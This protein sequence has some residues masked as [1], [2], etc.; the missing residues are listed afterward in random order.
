MNSATKNI[1]LVGPAHPLRGGIATFNEQLARSLQAQGH[2]VEILSFSLQYPDFIFPG[3]SQFTDEPPPTDLK[4][5]SKM[6]AINPL[7]WL[8]IGNEYRKKKY[9][10]IIFRFWLPLMSPCLGTIARLIRL[11]Q[12][13]STKILAITD[14]VIPH[15]KRIGDKIFTKYFLAACDGFIAMAKAVMEDINL[16]EPKKPKVYTPHPIYDNYGEEISREQALKNLNLS[17]ENQYILF[18][19]LIRA[20]KGLDLLLEAFADKRLRHEKVK[21]IIAGEPYESMDKYAQIIEK[22]NLKTEIIS[23]LHFIPTDQVANYFCAADLIA[24]PYKTAT[25]SGVSQI[26]YHFNKPMLVTDVGGLAETVPH[27]KVGYVT[28]QNPTEIANYLVDFFE[29]K[30]AEAF[31]TAIKIEKKRFEWTTLIE[32]LVE[33]SH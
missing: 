10:L 23:H 18:F 22:Y 21:L 12:P 16:F 29:N 33:L 2:S 24:Q 13:K 4:I 20:Y 17:P 25:Q 30:R 31:I 11:G 5:S 19:G 8:A 14:N 6:N 1:L 28:S 32:K 3:T 15:E 9:D 27:Q 26:A 7:N